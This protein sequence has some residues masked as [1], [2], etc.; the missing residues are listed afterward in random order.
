[1]FKSVTFQTHYFDQAL[2]KRNDFC[3]N[4][5]YMHFNGQK[6]SGVFGTV[7]LYKKVFGLITKNLIFFKKKGFRCSFYKMEVYVFTNWSIRLEKHQTIEI[8]LRADLLR[9]F[10]NTTFLRFFKIFEIHQYI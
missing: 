7:V 6:F 5:K 1:M 4:T 8:L 10:E 2:K 3:L 9:I